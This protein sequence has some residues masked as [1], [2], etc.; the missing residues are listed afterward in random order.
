MSGLPFDT[1]RTQSPH[2]ETEQRQSAL[3]AVPHDLKLQRGA[4][5]SF[6]SQSGELLSVVHAVPRPDPWLELRPDLFQ[7]GVGMNSRSPMEKVGKPGMNLAISKGR[8]AMKGRLEVHW[9]P[10]FI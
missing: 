5:G 1:W 9:I 10:F 6:I 7:I 3:P 8:K 2:V 4:R